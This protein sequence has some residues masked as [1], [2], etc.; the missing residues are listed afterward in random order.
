MRHPV[1]VV[2]VVAN[3]TLVLAGCG[4]D[5]SPA[6]DNPEDAGDCLARVELRDD[7]Y[8]PIDDGA[9]DAPRAAE[10]GKGQVIDCDGTPVPDFGMVTFFALVDVDPAMAVA[11]VGDDPRSDLD[12]IYVAEGIPA[13]ELPPQLK[14]G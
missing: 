3:V 4:N 10:L 11:V 13:V 2:A 7:V 9:Q 8:Q 14:T 12:G 6:Q 5:A 1:V